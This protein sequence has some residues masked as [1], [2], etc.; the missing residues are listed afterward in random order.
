MITF[1][2]RKQRSTLQESLNTLVKITENDFRELL[3]DKSNNYKFYSFDKRCNQILFIGNPELEYMWLYIQIDTIGIDVDSQELITK[4][5]E[6]GNYISERCIKSLNCYKNFKEILLKKLQFDDN[7]INFEKLVLTKNVDIRDLKA[8]FNTPSGL[9]QY[10]KHQYKENELTE[11]E[12]E[13]L[14]REIKKFE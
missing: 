13:F 3:L 8:Y 4:Y 7:A 5:L 10:N 11:E 12:F 14:K 1:G 6:L 2:K 9:E